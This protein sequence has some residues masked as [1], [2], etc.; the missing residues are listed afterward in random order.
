MSKCWK[1]LLRRIIFIFLH[2]FKARPLHHA[3][4][5]RPPSNVASKISFHRASMNNKFCF[6]P[7]FIVLQENQHTHKKRKRK[8]KGLWPELM[9]AEQWL[10][11]RRIDSWKCFPILWLTRAWNTATQTQPLYRSSVCT[12]S[13]TPQWAIVFPAS[14][15]LMPFLHALILHQTVHACSE[16]L[17]LLVVGVLAYSCLNLASIHTTI[18]KTQE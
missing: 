9:N 18:N 4:L 15:V 7:L 14:R 6:V 10:S 13:N 1:I 17:L 2:N 16:S 8:K 12:A 11:Q 5:H 3:R